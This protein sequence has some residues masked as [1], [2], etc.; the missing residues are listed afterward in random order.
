MMFA[1]TLV[2]LVAG[3][4]FAFLIIYGL[5][6]GATFVLLQRLVAEYFGNRDYARILGT[7]TMIEIFGGVIGGRITGYLADRAGG[8]YS[9]AFY[10]MIGVTAAAFICML[11]LNRSKTAKSESAV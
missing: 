1:S 7:I 9:T 10:V 3:A 2:L 4:P 6:Y 5:G 11:A 8:D